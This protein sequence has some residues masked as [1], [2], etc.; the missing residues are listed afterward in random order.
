ARRHL[1]AEVPER[2]S[3]EPAHERA[4]DPEREGPED[5]NGKRELLGPR[6]QRPWLTCPLGDRP[7]ERPLAVA[8]DEAPVGQDQAVGRLPPNDLEHLRERGNPEHAR[9][10]GDPDPY[11]RALWCQ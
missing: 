8:A 11:A 6:E 9:P 10:D 1:V 7:A 5:G 2:S 3:H 4:V